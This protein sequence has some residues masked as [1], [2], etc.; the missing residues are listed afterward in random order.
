LELELDFT[1]HTARARLDGGAWSSTH[2]INTD[3]SQVVTVTISNLS[4]T[5]KN[6]FDDL[7]GINGIGSGDTA[8][9]LNTPTDLQTLPDFQNWNLTW[10]NV[11]CDDCQVSVH[12]SIDETLLGTCDEFPY[13][14]GAGY[15]ECFNG[16]PRIYVDYGA[17]YSLDNGTVNVFKNTPF[18]T[19]TEYFAQVVLKE[20]STLG[21]NIIVSDVISFTIGVPEDDTPL[22]VECSTLDIFCHMRNLFNW[23]FIPSDDSLQ[24]LT[25]LTLAD[26]A[27]FSYLYDLPN[28]YDDLFNQTSPALGVTVE[29]SIG[30]LTLISADLIDNVPFQNEIY[31]IISAMIYFFTAMTLYRKIL[32]VHDK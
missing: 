10:Q 14:S 8:V 31:L 22:L 26:S 1:A 18:V 24:A 15:T 16:D 28:L 21:T 17:L 5:S 6:Y 19:G 23:A 2:V 20:D 30:D 25:S 32:R 13:G 12:Y 27:P 11:S 4:T 3:A 7:G 9:F 29:T